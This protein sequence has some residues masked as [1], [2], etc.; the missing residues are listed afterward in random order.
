[1]GWGEDAIGV[2]MLSQACKCRLVGGEMR[3]V[4]FKYKVV[5]SST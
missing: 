4:A 2:D 3:E 5:E 1:M